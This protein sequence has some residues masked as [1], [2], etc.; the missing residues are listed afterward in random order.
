MARTSNKDKALA[1]ATDK[2]IILT[3]EDVD[4]D[5]TDRDQDQDTDQDRD[6]DQDQD[7]DQDRDQ[8]QDQD[9]DQDRDQDLVPFPLDKCPACRDDRRPCSCGLL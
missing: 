7:T 1:Y 9:T 3:M 8:D 5:D 2:G 4:Q 6:Q